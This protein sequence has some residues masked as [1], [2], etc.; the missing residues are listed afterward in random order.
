[1]DGTAV[2]QRRGITPPTAAEILDC[3]DETVRRLARARKIRYWFVQGVG[4]KKRRMMVDAGDV[5]KLR[6]SS[7]PKS[8]SN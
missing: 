8:L 6:Q 5:E 3:C 2:E 1:M 4:E 7:L